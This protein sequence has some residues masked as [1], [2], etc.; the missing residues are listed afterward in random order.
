[1]KDL[2][3]MRIFSVAIVWALILIY[4][5]VFGWLRGAHITAKL[6]NI[7]CRRLRYLSI[8]NLIPESQTNPEDQ[9]RTCV[10]G[11]IE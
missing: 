11:L 10:F 6:G 9:I 4:V 7:C 8:H 3:Q 1:M 2:R 5:G